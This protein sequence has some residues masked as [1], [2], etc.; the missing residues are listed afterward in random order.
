M[1]LKTMKECLEGKHLYC[2]KIN[3]ENLHFHN[4]Y[5]IRYYQHQGELF[6]GTTSDFSSDRIKVWTSIKN[7]EKQVRKLYQ[8]PLCKGDIVSIIDE[9]GEVVKKFKE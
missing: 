8:Y 2:L 7:A 6:L 1:R 4:E 3:T 9:Y 5:F